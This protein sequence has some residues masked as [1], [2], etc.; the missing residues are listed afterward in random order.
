MNE[1]QIMERRRGQWPVGMILCGFLL[2]SWMLALNHDPWGPN[3]TRSERI[4]GYVLMGAG[5]VNGIVWVIR[6]ERKEKKLRE[7]G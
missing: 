4:G 5:I 6:E 7:E 1:Q 2:V 3:G